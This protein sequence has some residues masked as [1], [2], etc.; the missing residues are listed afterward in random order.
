MLWGDIQS[1]R[2]GTLRLMPSWTPP[3]AGLR[4]GSRYP[5]PQERDNLVRIPPLG[6]GRI[7]FPSVA[8]HLNGGLGRSRI[9]PHCGAAAVIFGA[10][11]AAVILRAFATAPPLFC[12]RIAA[13]KDNLFGSY[14]IICCSHRKY[15]KNLK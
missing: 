12:S 7:Y 15:Q 14:Y 3:L 13:R 11:Y 5:A 8:A 4:R 1:V 10:K 6:G 9:S 2:A